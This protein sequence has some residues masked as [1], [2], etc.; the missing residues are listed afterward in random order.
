MGSS[1]SEVDGGWWGGVVKG[2]LASI[3]V[4][5]ERRGGGRSQDEAYYNGLHAVNVAT[6]TVLPS[7]SRGQRRER[8]HCSH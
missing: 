7:S 2:P 8:E 3:L 6:R 4:L 1:A 5:L